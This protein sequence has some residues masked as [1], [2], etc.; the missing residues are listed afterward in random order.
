MSSAFRKLL[1]KKRVRKALIAAIVAALA[2][3]VS[4][5]FPAP[6]PDST[7]TRLD[8]TTLPAYSGAPYIVINNNIP[9]FSEDE[10]T[11]TAYETYSDLDAL[12]RCGAALASCGIETMPGDDE[13]RGSISSVTP[14]GWVQAEY[15][16]ISGKWLYNR[17]H[18]IG[19]QLSAENANKR[20]LVTGTNYLNIEGMLPFENMVADYIKETGNHVAYRVT[21]IF[22]GNNLL[23]S[24][25]EMEGYSIEDG[26]E[27][28]CFHVYCYNVQPGVS[29]NYATGEST[30]SPS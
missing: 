11:T 10:L 27:G 20:N 22:E 29:L 30:L 25:V 13:D 21:P 19:W 15:N 3:A 2:L 24:G 14:S 28:I 18:L 8:P 1:R 6:K 5:L 16:H 26:G 9:A 17:M 23:C 12:G 7:A 4:A